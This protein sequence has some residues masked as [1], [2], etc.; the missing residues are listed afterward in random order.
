MPQLLF[1]HDEI[2]KTQDRLISDIQQA[3]QKKSHLLI[4]AP[5]GIGKTAAIL[6]AVL[7]PST[8]LSLT[9]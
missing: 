1:P 7:T 3:I 9:P 2:R 8:G 4:H 5:T 6:S